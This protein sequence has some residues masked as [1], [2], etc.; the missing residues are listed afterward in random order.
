MALLL[1]R[2]GPLVA[3]VGLALYALAGAYVAYRVRRDSLV[4]DP[5]HDLD[6]HALASIVMCWPHDVQ[7]L[8]ARP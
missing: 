8:V 5:A 1:V 2:R 6:L 7:S 4:E 3:A